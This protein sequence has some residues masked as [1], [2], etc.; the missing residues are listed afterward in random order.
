MKNKIITFSFLGILFIFMIMHILF[1][2]EIISI[3]ER[4]NLSSFPSFEFT[5]EYMNK[6]EKYLLDHFPFRDEFRKLKANF[7]YKV[8][9]RY[10]NNG[11]YL[12][13]DGIY[14]SLYPTKE[15]SIKKFNEKIEGLQSLLSENNKTYMMIVPDK[16]Y[17]LKDENFLHL[18]YNFMYDEVSK[19]NMEHIDLRD[20]LSTSD[21]YSTD[22]HW[23]Q[24]NLDKVVKHM[25]ET[26]NFGYIEQDYEIH[27]FNEFYGV[28]YS[29]AANNMKP[30]T[31]KYLTNKIISESTVKYLE[32]DKLT[33][34]Y[35]E[36][37][38]GSLD[39]YEVY[40][41]GASSFIEITNNNATTDKELV[42][43]RDSFASSLTPLLINS[44][45]KITLIDNR[46]ITSMVFKDLIEFNNQDVLFMFNTEIINNSTILRG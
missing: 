8:L 32:N 40:L 22:T 12:N 37:N 17:Y 38:L 5:S 26:M 27:A 13:E 39:S 24:E 44:Y 4:R 15:G 18:D 36:G 23:K 3:T 10:E 29:E 45:S 7:N 16:N 19:L 33:T 21:Y 41:D 14:K 9:G 25:N 31:I 30:D 46:Y 6:V 34:V 35:N 11:I 2:D 28:Y 43:F 1:S 42:I 20:V